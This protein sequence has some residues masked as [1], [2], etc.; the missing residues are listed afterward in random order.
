MAS[1]VALALVACGDDVGVGSNQQN[2]ETG[3]TA[4]FSGGG[5]TAGSAGSGATLAGIWAATGT[6]PSG[7]TSQGS[8]MLSESRLKIQFPSL[9]FDFQE[10]G[11]TATASFFDDG[12]TSL[13]NFSRTNGPAITTGIMPLDIGGNWQASVAG[14]PGLC[15]GFL[16]SGNGSGSCVNT[17]YVPMP[18]EPMNGSG[19]VVKSKAGGDD[20]FGQLTGTWVYKSNGGGQCEV[21][22]TSST[23]TSNCSGMG[24]F[25]GLLSVSFEADTVSGTTSSGIEFSATRTQ[26]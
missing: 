18:L 2:Q 8:I 4:G 24:R 5:G 15:T 17:G 23:F 21:V 16:S 19:F 25:D 11:N 10:D 14:D 12:V 6:G 9:T 20:T 3:G 13:L 7:T 26:P 22:F 1:V